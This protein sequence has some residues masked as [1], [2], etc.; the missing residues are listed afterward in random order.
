MYTYIKRNQMLQYGCKCILSTTG[1]YG[2]DCKSFMPH[3][4]FISIEGRALL[5]PLLQRETIG[6]SLY[7]QINCSDGAYTW[8]G[9]YFCFF[10]PDRYYWM[11]NLCPFLLFYGS[12][13]GA[14]KLYE[15]TNF[16]VFFQKYTSFNWRGVTCD[17]AKNEKFLRD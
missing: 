15:E 9:N 10:F 4:A 17:Q 2:G 13:S 11:Y 3:Q 7:S 12:F 6:Y 8:N 5:L 14:E 1:S 16:R